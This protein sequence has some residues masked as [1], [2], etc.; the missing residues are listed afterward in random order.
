LGENSGLA[1]QLAIYQARYGDWRELFYNIDRLQKV[2]KEDIRRVANSTF[3]P[4]N[5][6]VAIVQTVAP[7]A[8][9]GGSGGER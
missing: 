4:T 6:T 8:A 5:R 7:A 2:T 1:A 9:P 3:T